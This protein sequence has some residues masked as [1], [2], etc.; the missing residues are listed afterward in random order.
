MAA[1]E[2]ARN[3]DV[4]QKQLKH[5]AGHRKQSIRNVLQPRSKKSKKSNPKK[6]PKKKPDQ[7]KRKL[8]TPTK[9]TS[10]KR[11]LKTPTSEDEEKVSKLDQRKRKLKTPTKNASLKRQLKTP[12]SEDED[13]RVSKKKGPRK[14]LMYIP[15]EYHNKWKQ[16]CG[17]SLKER[18]REEYK[19]AM[20][21]ALNQAQVS[22]PSFKNRLQTRQFSMTPDEYVDELIAHGFGKLNPSIRQ[23]VLYVQKVMGTRRQKYDDEDLEEPKKVS[24]EDSEALA[25]QE[26]LQKTKKEGFQQVKKEGFQKV[27]KE[28]LQEVKKEVTDFKCVMRPGLLKTGRIASD[29]LRCCAHLPKG[30]LQKTLLAMAYSKSIMQLVKEIENSGKVALA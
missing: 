2:G 9:N 15:K 23:R 1:E 14:Y 12:T 4:A 29:M 22:F 5:T 7:R 18:K 26:P 10:S 24:D 17:L 30:E 28:S 25:L 20:N 13:K 27:K 11:Q 16:K 21:R 19:Y 8:K 3:K 6:E